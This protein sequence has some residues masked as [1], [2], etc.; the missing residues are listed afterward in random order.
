MNLPGTAVRVVRTGTLPIG[1]A[2]PAFRQ[3]R[4]TTALIT[5]PGAT[6]DERA[7]NEHHCKTRPYSRGPR[8]FNYHAEF[9]PRFAHESYFWI[10]G[11]PL[12]SNP[13]RDSRCDSSRTMSR[14]A[15][16]PLFSLPPI[17]PIDRPCLE[18]LMPLPFR[19][20]RSQD[21]SQTRWAS[22]MPATNE[23]AGRCRSTPGTGRL[24][25]LRRPDSGIRFG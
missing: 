22:S 10:H 18:K 6:L 16:V 15:S 7:R 13:P 3:T 5:Q 9:L 4:V 11:F 2:S 23:A 24:L 1:I 8:R 14:G 20:A 17:G 19:I 21:F 25:L 12:E